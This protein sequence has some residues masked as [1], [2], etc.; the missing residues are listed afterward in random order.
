M[1]EGSLRRAACVPATQ[2]DRSPPTPSKRR[3]PLR[4]SEKLIG[5]AVTIQV[6]RTDVLQI[7]A[8]W[9]SEKASSDACVLEC[10]AAAPLWDDARHR[11]GEWVDAHTGRQCFEGTRAPPGGKRAVASMAGAPHPPRHRQRD[12]LQLGF[13]P[14]F[15]SFKS[16]RTTPRSFA[17][18]H[19]CKEKMTCPFIHF[20]QFFNP[21]DS[22][23]VSI[24]GL[25][26]APIVRQ[27]FFGFEEDFQDG[28]AILRR[29]SCELWIVVFPRQ[30]VVQLLQDDLRDRRGDR[31]E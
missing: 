17:S 9:V 28:F 23:R 25:R 22:P 4:S 27:R 29:Q 19:Q 10:G 7:C 26:F 3:S 30:D 12:A 11:G 2:F 15:R 1:G 24:G 8:V 20:I 16:E 31:V 13:F 6:N 14:S 5:R 21:L 18:H